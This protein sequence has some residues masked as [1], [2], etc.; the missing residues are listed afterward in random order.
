MV[1][2]GIYTPTYLLTD[3]FLVHITLDLGGEANLIVFYR[4][5]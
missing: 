1:N 3:D 4:N 2:K 5:Y